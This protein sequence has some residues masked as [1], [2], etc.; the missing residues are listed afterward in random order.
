MSS[1]ES[2]AISHYEDEVFPLSFSNGAFEPPMLSHSP[3][4]STYADDFSQSYQQELLTSPL[5]YPIVDES[6]CT[7]AKGKTDSNIITGTED[8][9]IF[10]MEFSG[11]GVVAAAKE[12]A[13]ASS[14]AL[15]SNDAFANVAQQNYRLWL[16]SV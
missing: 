7:R 10:D 9:F 5:S 13:A 8:S 3:D 4:R 14:F 2:A 12:S 15:T 6:E 11:S 16:S 1:V